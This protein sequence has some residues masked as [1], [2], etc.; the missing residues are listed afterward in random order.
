MDDIADS[1]AT[2]L[3]K[4]RKARGLTQDELANRAGIAYSTVAKLE[5]GAIKSP[6]LNTTLA[7]AEVLGVDVKQLLDGDYSSGAEKASSKKV[8]FIYWDVNDVLV[9]YFHRALVVIANESDIP[10]NKVENTYWH[11]NTAGNRGDI[12]M[13][14]FN[15]YLGKD[16]GIKNFKWQNYYL[17]AIEPIKEAVDLMVELSKKIETGLLTDAFPTM[18]TRMIKDG[19]LPDLDYKAVIESSEVSAVKPEPKIYQIA[20]EKSGHSGSEILFVDNSRNN[21]MAAAN[22]NW[23]VTWF[24]DVRPKDSAQ[25]VR[26]AVGL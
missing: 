22:L 20:Q 10:L 17:D 26:E 7:V 6:T 5:Q 25:R 19:I 3:K 13:Q 14:Q 12:T 2:N 15:E 23:Q 9:H 4:I 11:Y 1:L 8:K 24:D 21:L 16:F 18:T